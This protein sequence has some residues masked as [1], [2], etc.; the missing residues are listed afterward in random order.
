MDL[1][2]LESSDDDPVVK[3]KGL[4]SITT[5]TSRISERPSANTPSN[6]AG[7]GTLAHTNT[8]ASTASISTV[9]SGKTLVSTTVLDSPKD[10]K[11]MYPFR[12]KHLGRPESYTLY[13]PS[14]QN[15]LDWCD[16]II[17]AKTRHAASLFAQ[18]AEPFKLRVIA[19]SAFANDAMS[20]AP[21]S[22]TI[23]GTPLDRAIRE[24]EDQFS[25]DPKPA[26]VCR[27]IVNCAVAFHQPY[28][29]P[30]LAIG[31]DYGV[32]ITPASNPRGWHRV[33]N[34]PRVTQI[35]VLEEFSLF[36]VLTDKAL[37][38]HHLDS[39]CPV[40]GSFPQ[41]PN[42]NDGSSRRA[43]QKLSGSRDVGF[44]VTG[45]MK[46]RTL[47]FYKKKDGISSTF[48]ILEPVYHKSNQTA[49]QPR[50]HHMFMGIRKGSIDYFRDFDDFYI[51]AETY[52][53]N[54]FHSSIAIASQRGIEVMTLDKK[55]PISI[56]DLKQPGCASIA[57]RIKDQRPLG[58]FRLSES[59]FLLVFEDVGIYVDKLGDVSRA[60]I[61]EFVGKAKSA[62]L[63]QSMYLV[64]VDQAGAF[65]EVRNAINGRLKQV[66]P[67]RDVRMLDDGMGS[68][69]GMGGGAIN[70]GAGGKGGTVKIAMQHP[71]WERG[72]VVVEMVINEGMKE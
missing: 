5:V 15:R 42:G 47:V 1:L 57:A 39:V 10:E 26:P 4:G 61:M 34:S 43:P 36:L 62:T 14:A 58:M 51:P 41:P 28:N 67:G 60:V 48:K 25:G 8:A 31:T 19:D 35:S 40:S 54:L 68:N 72:Q 52:A 22:V 55:L 33:L 21:R 27:A 3:S 70:V 53:L 45:R 50:R 18:N 9:G 24:V 12:V 71:E 63:V 66:V 64:L 29:N 13:A 56:P 2:I 37:V 59:E 65:V 32:Y 30:V 16:K 38:A 23:K 11:A 7:P 6:T 20:V 69:G 49:N 17:E 44:F 46:D